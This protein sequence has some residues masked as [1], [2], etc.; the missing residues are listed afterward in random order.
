MSAF[1]LLMAVISTGNDDATVDFDSQVIPI[2]TKASCNTGACHGAAVGRG[3]F[4]LS[5]YGGD[6]DLDF[7][8]IVLDLEGRRVNLS[9]PCPTSSDPSAGRSPSPSGQRDPKEA[10]AARTVRP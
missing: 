7:R 5:L 10:P 3:G 9:Q 1:V 2:L 4:K 6:P 8:S